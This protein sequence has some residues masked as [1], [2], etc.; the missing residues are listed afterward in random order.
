M[1][2]GRRVSSLPH[3]MEAGEGNVGREVGGKPRLD[4]T[5]LSKPT[6]V[7]RKGAS[8]VGECKDDT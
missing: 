7:G 3:V 6:C 1:H 2:T 8:G 4:C 5:A